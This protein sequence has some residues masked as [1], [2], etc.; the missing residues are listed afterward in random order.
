MGETSYLVPPLVTESKER[1]CMPPM[2]GF[3]QRRSC[4]GA[5]K[6]GSEPQFSTC[7]DTEYEMAALK[8]LPCFAPQPEHGQKHKLSDRNPGL[9]RPRWNRTG[10]A[11]VGAGQLRHDPMQQ[12]L[13]HIPDHGMKP[14]T[15][16]LGL[17]QRAEPLACRLRTRWACFRRM[18]GLR[19]DLGMPMAA[20]RGGSVWI[21][22]TAI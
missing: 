16:C 15:R 18:S 19:R 17:R 14:R 7:R 10:G 13:S 11:A 3:I 4:F 20:G 22:Y 21:G 12:N 2:L 5:E 9:Y 6:G 8:S 1:R